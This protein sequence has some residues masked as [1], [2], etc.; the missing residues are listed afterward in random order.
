[1]RGLK[2]IWLKLFFF[3]HLTTLSVSAQEVLS[4]QGDSYMNGTG[5]IDFTIGEVIINTGTD[6]SNNPCARI[7]SKQL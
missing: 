5:S 6:G 2:I 4:T 1:M 3:S 7:P